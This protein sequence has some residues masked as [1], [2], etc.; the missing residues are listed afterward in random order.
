M[1]KKDIKKELEK[2]KS[3]SENIEKLSLKILSILGDES[4]TDS[5]ALLEEYLMGDKRNEN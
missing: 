5:S 1:R 3:T 2:I 4:K